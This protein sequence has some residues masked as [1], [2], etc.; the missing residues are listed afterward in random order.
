ML[1]MKF[2]KLLLTTMSAVMAVCSLLG[3][4]GIK[5]MGVSAETNSVTAVEQNVAVD[6]ESDVTF[7]EGEIVE[8]KG[9]NGSN[10]LRL[11]GSRVSPMITLPE[12][13]TVYSNYYLVFWID[14][15]GSS[16]RK[17]TAAIKANGG[18]YCTDNNDGKYPP[19]WYIADGASKW[20]EGVHGTDGCFGYEDV[21]CTAPLEGFKGWIAVGL[22]DMLLSGEVSITQVGFMS[23]NDVETTFYLDNF[24]IVDDYM[25][26]TPE[27]EVEVPTYNVGDTI[28]VLD[29]S[30]YRVTG[31]AISAE[32][33]GP[34]M[35][36]AVG[37]RVDTN[38][39]MGAAG[40]Y[41]IDEAIKW[42]VKEFEGKQAISNRFDHYH[43]CITENS[44]MFYMPI[45][46]SDITK[47][48]IEVYPD[49]AADE[50]Y[51]FNNNGG[52]RLFAPDDDGLEWEE[53]YTI[54]NV[55]QRQWVTVTIE[56][57][58][59]IDR[60]LDGK[61]YFSGLQ[62]GTCIGNNWD[63]G[64]FVGSDGDR[65]W[66]NL[67][68][69]KVYTGEKPD[70]SSY[71]DQMAKSGLLLA[72]SNEGHYSFGEGTLEM[73]NGATLPD[74]TGLSYR[75]FD[76][77]KVPGSYSNNAFVVDFHSWGRVY[78]EKSILF[79]KTM[80]VNQ[81]E[82]LIIRMYCHFSASQEY[83]TNQGGVR[84]YGIGQTGKISP[85]Y[86]IPK[87][88][89]QDEWITLL[90]TKEELKL[91]VDT[92]GKLSGLQV[93]A[94]IMAYEDTEFWLGVTGAYIAIDYVSYSAPVNITFE[95]DGEVI[96]TDKV[97]ASANYSKAFMPQKEGYVFA[98]WYY[99]D[100]DKAYSFSDVI[101][102]DT[103][104]V[105]EWVEEIDIAKNAGL[106]FMTG[107]AGTIS[108]N[109]KYLQINEDGSI[110]FADVLDYT[111]VYYG[112]SASM[113]YVFDKNYKVSK[114]LLGEGSF[115]KVAE[116]VTLTYDFGNK[117]ERI[118]LA[119]GDCL[120]EKPAQRVG[121]IFEGWLNVNGG[122]Y[123]FSKPI[124]EDVTIVAD[125]SYN[126]IIDDYYK[127]Y[128]GKFYNA[129][130]DSV[131]V[132]NQN[133][134]YINGLSTG[135]YRLLDGGLLLLINDDK[136][137]EYTIYPQRI[138]SMN[139]EQWFK[140]GQYFVIFE[141]NDGSGQKS[142]PIAIS[143]ET[144]KIVKPEDPIKEGYAFKGWTLANGTAFDFE[145]VVTS[146]VTLYAKWEKVGGSSGGTSDKND[147][148][149][150]QSGCYSTLSCGALTAGLLALC[151]VFV[152]KKKKD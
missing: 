26:A 132:L 34:G 91:L 77:K 12:T 10:A 8:G 141:Q 97:Y 42:E 45:K 64:G 113:L 102:A 135:E 70:N 140:M 112:L 28:N 16:F 30:K 72:S 148:N 93:G 133:K 24:M 118:L 6:F 68:A 122:E 48:E 56:D 61:G 66:L 123:D 89:I 88:V 57:V 22:C 80:D 44:L 96:K 108:A 1:R 53:G 59:T 21:G 119:K 152:I 99:K 143:M 121:Y 82:T 7:S 19:I 60:L 20:T 79:K 100:T 92:E 54:P 40:L 107:A 110:N 5:A 3:F 150:T 67:G 17:A 116:T 32:H 144:Y 41:I 117:T 126:E 83:L 39:G 105:A 29:L 9:Y 151:G 13:M 55:A 142:D 25:K 137:T 147:A 73:L 106:Y 94:H 63:A 74:D 103:V 49:Y 149:S 14:M 11:S 76:I 120:M 127:I 145:Q 37:G 43:V 46:G 35:L 47:I 128:E 65:A 36:Q 69:I 139:G 114:I 31:T 98:G 129:V 4:V 101:L 62:V 51:T 78:S 2:K 23:F 81:I 124:N 33:Y 86:M 85:G 52:I 71:I 134:S 27:I 50:N 18:A 75:G 90:L 130:T 136:T 138:V 95:S 109:G 131:I 15:D 115:E 58:E 38:N 111:P 84:L 125:W 104:V 146:S 87:N